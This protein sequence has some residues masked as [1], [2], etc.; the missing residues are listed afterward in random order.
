MQANAVVSNLC[1]NRLA[2]SRRDISASLKTAV[3]C[4][5]NIKPRLPKITVFAIALSIL[6]AP[7]HT[8]SQ[9][10]SAEDEDWWF[11][12]EIIA[13]KRNT[14]SSPLEEDFSYTGLEVSLENV[15]DLISLPL[16]RE[17]NPLI[18]LQQMVYEC[19]L[20]HSIFHSK[21][22]ALDAVTNANNGI[23]VDVNA[24]GKVNNEVNKQFET[25]ESVLT[26]EERFAILYDEQNCSTAKKDLASSFLIINNSNN[27]STYLQQP[28]LTISENTHLL[29]DTQLT[30]LD[31]AKKVFAQRDISALSHIAWRQPVVFGENNAKFYRVFSGDKLRLPDEPV[32]SYA[33]LKERYD[34]EQ[35][36][37]IDQNSETFF[38]ELKQQLAEGKAVNWQHRENIQASSS[39]SKTAIDNIWELDGKVKIYL[40]YVNRVPYLHIDS[41]FGFNELELNSVGEAEIK[42]YPFKQRRR[43]ISKQIHYFDHP[44]I[45]II[46]RLERY[47]QPKELKEVNDEDIY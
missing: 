14:S 27:I 43:V 29:A 30:L 33:A 32:A 44:K 42:Q 4:V 2:T 23:E 41:E 20:N 38:A 31:Y 35:N 28:V 47:E 34:P 13:F 12:V 36:N 8:S 1:I 40:N 26:T 9:V 46:M 24:Y 3:S 37:V 21:L 16:Y 39:D 25:L 15:T 22:A 5:A 17:A 10:S 6:S 18:D 7:M 11:D 45:G 19:S